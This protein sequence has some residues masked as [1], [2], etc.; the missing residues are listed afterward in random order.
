MV[1]G[2]AMMI[3]KQN[4]KPKRMLS[5]AWVHKGNTFLT[6]SHTCV[7]IYTYVHMH[8]RKYLQKKKQIK[9]KKTF[10]VYIEL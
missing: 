5:H 3:G 2:K 4:L 9:K 8:V 1:S 7:H 6:E 10:K